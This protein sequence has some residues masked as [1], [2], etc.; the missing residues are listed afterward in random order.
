MGISVPEEPDPSRGISLTYQ[1]FLDAIDRMREVDFPIERDPA[2]AWPGFVGWRV[3]YEQAAYAIA[4]DLYAVRA[5]WSG[6]SE[7]PVPAIPP[8]RPPPG[9]PPK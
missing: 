8:L 4:A 3:N 2:D 7:P 1:E 6:T 5:L 9:R